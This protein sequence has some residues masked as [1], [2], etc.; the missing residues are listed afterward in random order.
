MPN[1]Y[2]IGSQL[3]KQRP[4]EID[5]AEFDQLQQDVLPWLAMGGGLGGVGAG[6]GAGTGAGEG[7]GNFNLGNVLGTIG[8]QILNG[9]IGGGAPETPGGLG[10]FPE[11]SQRP[12]DVIYDEQTNEWGRWE[13]EPISGEP[14][15]VP[16]PR[17]GEG[18]PPEPVDAPGG[19]QGGSSGEPSRIPD[20]GFGGAI[21]GYPG[22]YQGDPSTERD[23]GQVLQGLGSIFGAG[24]GGP[25]PIGIASGIYNIAKGLTGGE[26]NTQQVRDATAQMWQRQQDQQFSNF[27]NEA[28]T[29][30][31]EMFDPNSIA[32]WEEILGRG[33]DP[34]S[35]VEDPF[36]KNTSSGGS[37]WEQLSR[38]LNPYSG[39]IID[40]GKYSFTDKYGFQPLPGYTPYYDADI[41]EKY[42]QSG[43]YDY[44]QGGYAGDAPTGWEY[45]NREILS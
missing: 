45:L 11:G 36:V 25:G 33:I 41:V 19:Q 22:V 38:T 15:F 35:I 3:R 13:V 29:A 7:S 39:S 43:Y 16:Y 37:V 12:D 42:G 9:Q 40:Q 24:E 18:G 6:T 4:V 34:F 28:Q 17:P 10:G 32:N 44:D 20:F 1:P 8:G 26:S 31:P 27:M 30:N 2:A 21:Y 14:I 5:T 23:P